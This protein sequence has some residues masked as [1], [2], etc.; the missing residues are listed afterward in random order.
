MII[1]LTRTDGA[2]VTIDT[3]DITVLSAASAAELNALGVAQATQVDRV[4]SSIFVT[5][6]V[7]YIEGLM[8]AGIGSESPRV[9]ASGT[10]TGATGALQGGQGVAS[11]ARSAAGEYTVTLNAAP[12]NGSK[13]LAT[14]L[15][16][17]RILSSAPF[18]GPTAA[19]SARNDLGVAADADFTFIV[20]AITANP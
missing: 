9:L 14:S 19:L 4:G 6:S 13:V 15:T 2:P 20:V 12:P 1:T 18:V 10:V 7:T 16:A 3:L 11:S 17:D 5:E 8:A